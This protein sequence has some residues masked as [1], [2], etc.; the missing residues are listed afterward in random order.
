[1]LLFF[2]ATTMF[3]LVKFH[4]YRKQEFSPLWWIWLCT[5]GVSIGCVC[6]YISYISDV[7]L[8]SNG[9]DFLEWPLS[10]STPQKIYG[11]NLVI[12][13]C[14]WY[15]HLLNPFNRS[16]YMSGIGLPGSGVSS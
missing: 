10:A 14:Q 5:T 9:L 3:S 13:K 1:M 8:V 11:I 7:Y 16:V 15:S 2:T 12:L 4:S 6:R